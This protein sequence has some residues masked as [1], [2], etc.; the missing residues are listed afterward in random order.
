M[1][2]SCFIIFCGI[3]ASGKST[4]AKELIHKDWKIRGKFVHFIYINYDDFIPE[5]LPVEGTTLSI[6]WKA[7]RRE[8]LKGIEELLLAKSDISSD[9]LNVKSRFCENSFVSSW[10]PCGGNLTTRYKWFSQSWMTDAQTGDEMI[11][12]LK[13]WFSISKN[14]LY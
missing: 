2:D 5:N 7:K 3:P 9:A 4:L 1:A 13:W 8:I 11:S 12:I 14:F 10:C 6:K